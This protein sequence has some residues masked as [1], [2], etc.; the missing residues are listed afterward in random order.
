M[1]MPVFRQARRSALAASTIL[2]GAFAAVPAGAQ[3]GQS[4]EWFVPNQGQGRAPAQAQPSRPQQRPPQQQQRPATEAPAPLPPGQK[5]PEA[6][7][8]IVDV[9]EIQR[10]STA[11]NQV[12]E[13]IEKRREKLNADL[14]REQ[15]R[16]REEQTGLAN[17]RASLPPDQL[18]QRERD[19][20]DRITDS[21]RIFRE[22]SRAIEQAAQQALAEIEQGL[23]SVIR[24]VAASRKVNLVLPRPLVI[25]N[26]PAFDLTEEVAS[27]FNRA[28]RSVTLAPEQTGEAPAAAAPAAAPAR[29]SAP[30][31]AAPRR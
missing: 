23:G 30:A 13:E 12:R 1:H 7:I 3:Q 16:W 5:P 8:G 6:V 4:P 18:R 31:P 25:F 27:Q 17:Q 22:R 19:L 28:L 21:Q 11:F 2:M 15:A 29:P 9:P 20:Q 10:V 24:Q 14:Q 26:D